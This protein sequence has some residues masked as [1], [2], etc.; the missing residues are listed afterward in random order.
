MHGG[1]L[2]Q[3]TLMKTGAPS[4]IPAPI[5]RCEVMVSLSAMTAC[6]RFVFTDS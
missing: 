3:N 6:H 1:A 4:A 5:V 2:E